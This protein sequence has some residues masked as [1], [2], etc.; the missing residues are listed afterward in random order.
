MQYQ[1]LK[2]RKYLVT[3]TTYLVSTWVVTLNFSWTYFL[4][5]RKGRYLRFHDQNNRLS[6]FQTTSSNV[7]L[8][9]PGARDVR[10][11]RARQV[12]QM[13]ARGS[14]V[15]ARLCSLKLRRRFAEVFLSVDESILWASISI[16]GWLPKTYGK[17]WGLSFTLLH[18][19]DRAS[20][21]TTHFPAPITFEASKS[22]PRT[23]RF[24]GK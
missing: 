1:C 16:P 21:L 17:A 3:S 14:R 19:V 15:A 8:V 23:R 9:Y 20:M 6:R 10:T 11:Y 7:G 22:F 24:Q 13:A 12:T 18:N 4:L 2:A 5:C